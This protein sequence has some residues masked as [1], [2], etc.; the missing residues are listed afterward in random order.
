MSSPANPPH[1]PDLAS[2][3]ELLTNFAREGKKEDALTTFTRIRN[4]GH[5]PNK[6]TMN[7]IINAHAKVGDLA[8]VLQYFDLQRE[9]C[10][11]CDTY[12]MCSIIK[13]LLAHGG[14]DKFAQILKYVEVMEGDKVEKNSYV[15]LQLFLA[16]TECQQ[17]VK[18]YNTHDTFLCAI[19]I[20]AHHCASVHIHHAC[21]SCIHVYIFKHTQAQ[22]DSTLS[23]LTFTF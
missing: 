22:Q 21:I 4:L 10:G 7:A 23:H 14:E 16:C 12:S 17:P 11:A 2:M 5:T 6:V 9:I 19:Y 15:Y 8:G 18:I 20:Q 13:M 1:R 3:N